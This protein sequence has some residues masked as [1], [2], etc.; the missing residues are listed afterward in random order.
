MNE[1][2]V[3]VPTTSGTFTMSAEMVV[4]QKRKIH[5]IM[6]SAF[7]AGVHYGVVPGTSGKPSLYKP[8][9]EYLCFAFNLRPHTE[10]EKQIDPVTGHLTC[11]IR[12][13]VHSSDGTYLGDGNAVASTRESKYAF[14]RSEVTCPKCGAPAIIKGKEEYGGGW[15]CFPRKGGCG[16]RFG[17]EDA[18]IVNQK[19]NTPTNPADFYNTVVKMGQKRAIVAAMLLTTAASEVFTQDLEEIMDGMNSGYLESD[20]CDK[21]A[22]DL[23]EAGG[24]V[25]RMLSAL[26]I[27]T[28]YDLKD[29]HLRTVTETIEGHRRRKTAK[30][31]GA[32][33]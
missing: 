23:T 28:I 6:R 12:C 5:D 29:D 14:K 15:Y 26:G 7:V 2:A 33:K 13:L 19:S 11:F 16:E 22:A 30:T 21:I 4:E 24:S 27:G 10:I 17:A 3:G 31:T 1:N 25:D 9:A 8:G 20:I 32:Q 18:E